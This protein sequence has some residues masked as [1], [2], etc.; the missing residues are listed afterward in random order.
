[1]YNNKELRDALKESGVEPFS[2]KYKNIITTGAKRITD[3]Q[4]SE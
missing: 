2:D 1:L 4:M 3:Y